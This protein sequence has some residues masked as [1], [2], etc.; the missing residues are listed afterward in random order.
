MQIHGK[1][2]TVIDNTGKQTLKDVSEK[3]TPLL[4][5]KK[6][7]GHFRVTYLGKRELRLLVLMQRSPGRVEI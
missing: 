4:D 7:K 2:L 3:L 1:D 6:I 5:Q